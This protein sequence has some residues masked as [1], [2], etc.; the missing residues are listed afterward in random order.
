MEERGTEMHT[1]A[2]RRRLAPRGL[3]HLIAIPVRLHH[4]IQVIVLLALPCIRLNADAAADADAVR[5]LLSDASGVGVAAGT[6]APEIGLKDQ[7]GRDRDRRS[8]TGPNGLVLVFFRSA[9]W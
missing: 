2:P 7:N 9:D 6:A 4:H 3:L 8:L 1:G 5:R